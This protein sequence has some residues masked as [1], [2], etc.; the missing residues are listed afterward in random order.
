MFRPS[1]LNLGCNRDQH[2]KNRSDS[3]IYIPWL[4]LFFTSFLHL[5]LDNSHTGLPNKVSFFESSRFYM[6][7]YTSKLCFV[8]GGVG[9]EDGGGSS[10]YEL[11]VRLDTDEQCRNDEQLAR[12]IQET[13]NELAAAEFDSSSNATS[14]RPQRGYHPYS[15]SHPSSSTY[16]HGYHHQNNNSYRNNNSSRSNCNIL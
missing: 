11:A 14:Q 6:S 8:Q 2:V 10:D 12:R 16:H 7:F 1:H 5:Y 15:S 4:F 3:V 9:T 13:E